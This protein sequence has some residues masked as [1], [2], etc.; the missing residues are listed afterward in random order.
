V[1]DLAVPAHHQE[2]GTMI[3]PGHGRICDE[4]DVAEYR[5]MLVIFRDRIRD[6]MQRGMTI[7]Q[8]KAARPTLDYDPE[9]GSSSGAWTIDLFVEAMYKSLQAGKK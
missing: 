8:I 5:D 2:G 1:L 7:E 9:F 3:V 6:M 4:A